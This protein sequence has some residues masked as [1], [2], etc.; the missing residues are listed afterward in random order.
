MGKR[1]MKQTEI[2]KRMQRGESIPAYRPSAA[3]IQLQ[4]MWKRAMES[5]DGVC[6]AI[7]EPLSETQ[8]TVLAGSLAVWFEQ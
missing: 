2:H 5:L 7:G 4:P 6:A 3:A 1:N 8:R